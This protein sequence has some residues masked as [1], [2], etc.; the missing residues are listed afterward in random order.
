MHRNA[1]GLG[2]FQ[3]SRDVLH[4]LECHFAFVDFLDGS[5]L[6]GVGQ[7]AEDHAVLENFEEVVHVSRNVY[8]LTGDFLDPF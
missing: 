5:W 6:E 3:E 4:A 2:G 7:L 8:G 1:E